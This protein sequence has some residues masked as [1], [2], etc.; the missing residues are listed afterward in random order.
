[1]SY[2]IGPVFK[3]RKRNN[4]LKKIL[5]NVKKLALGINLSGAF[6]V[7]NDKRWRKR[8]GRSPL[9]NKKGKD[10]GISPSR[11]ARMGGGI[12]HNSIRIKKWKK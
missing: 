9:W 5:E 6:L 1:M 2:Q 8:R 3:S 4:N 7:I 11:E 10:G 12:E